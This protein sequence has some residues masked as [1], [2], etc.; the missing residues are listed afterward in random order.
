MKCIIADDEPLALNLLTR[1]VKQHES[2]ELVGTFTNAMETFQGL[3]DRI[4]DLMFLDIRMPGISGLDLLKSLKNPPATILISAYSEY[5]VE[6]F[7]LEVADYLLKPVT[8]D[9]FKKSIDRVLRRENREAPADPDYTYFKVSRDLVKVNHEDLYYIQSIK[10]YVLV[11]S[12]GGNHISYMT[13]KYLEDILPSSKFCRIHRSYI[14]NLSFIEQV[15][16]SSVIVKGTE[17]PLSESYRRN[18]LQLIR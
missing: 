9:R 16:K 13:M 1:Y 7:N 14:V 15:K 12:G 3:N 4:V 5:A 11:K 8:Y 10:D 2:L 17:L 18:L 6:G